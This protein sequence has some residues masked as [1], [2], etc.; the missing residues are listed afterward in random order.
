ML[1]IILSVLV[2][3]LKMQQK[4]PFLPTA[5]LCK[6]DVVQNG[7]LILKVLNIFSIFDKVDNLW[8]CR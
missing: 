7:F 3:L 4:I 1:A 6:A 2:V 8:Q 5:A